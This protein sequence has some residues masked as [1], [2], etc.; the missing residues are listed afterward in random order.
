[1]SR[2]YRWSHYE[3]VCCSAPP[4]TYPT[5][6]LIWD[7]DAY[8]LP[9]GMTRIGYDADD[10]TYSYRDERGKI[11]V[12]SPGARY[13]VLQPSP[14]VSSIYTTSVALNRS[15][16]GANLRDVRSDPSTSDSDDESSPS[17]KFLSFSF[18]LL[19]RLLA[20]SSYY[21]SRAS[22]AASNRL[23]SGRETRSFEAVDS[24]SASPTRH[25]DEEGV[26]VMS[27]LQLATAI[28][29][30]LTERKKRLSHP[31]GTRKYGV[32]TQN[33]KKTPTW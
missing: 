7:Q 26:P 13:G 14:L 22:H 5:F 29:R 24:D 2:R 12:G 21:L 9:E 17:A 1:M 11:Y 16:A 27:P 33:E 25:E 15:A 32:S 31:R 20:I 18:E 28:G 6:S 3:S 30:H 23:S 19:R 8:R 10:G 4:I